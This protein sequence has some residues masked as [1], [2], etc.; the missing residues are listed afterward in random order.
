MS[1]ISDRCVS[2]VTLKVYMYDFF[3]HTLTVRKINNKSN[4][5]VPNCFF[6][7]DI[8]IQHLREAFKGMI[9][10]LSWMENATKIF[11]QEKV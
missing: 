3:F 8:M 11:A 4:I 6:Q 5:N 2:I 10:E 1:A 9:T 7:V